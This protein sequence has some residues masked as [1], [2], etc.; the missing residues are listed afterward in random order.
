VVTGKVFAVPTVYP[1]DVTRQVAMMETQWIV[2]RRAV[3]Q[4][5][6]TDEE[7]YTTELKKMCD[8]LAVPEDVRKAAPRVKF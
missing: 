7:W 5:K 2:F 3:R 1:R 4:G 8:V 6:S